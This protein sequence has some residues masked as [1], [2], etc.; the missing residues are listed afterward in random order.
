MIPSEKLCTQFKTSFF[1]SFHKIILT[2]I[3]IDR[4]ENINIHNAQLLLVRAIPKFAYQSPLM[5][6][7]T[8][9]NQS[10]IV[11]DACKQVIE[12]RWKGLFKTDVQG[13]QV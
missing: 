2:L 10:F 9:E 4:C 1:H 8:A 6:A 3:H 7:K 12:G 13:F 5:L 11:T